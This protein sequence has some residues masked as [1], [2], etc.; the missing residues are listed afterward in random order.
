M[1]TYDEAC[2]E[3]LT[4]YRIWEQTSNS[5]ITHEL[6]NVYDGLSTI[7]NEEPY[8]CVQCLQELVAAL[9]VRCRRC[10]ATDPMVCWGAM[11]AA[12][13]HVLRKRR[14]LLDDEEPTP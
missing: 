12:F 2:S 4:I 1:I 6:V 3:I 10:K 13:A 9:G 7:I 5:A 8:N 11:H 14:A